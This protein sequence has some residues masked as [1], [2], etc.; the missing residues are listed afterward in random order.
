MFLGESCSRPLVKIEWAATVLNQLLENASILRAC[1]LNA[2]IN[3]DD[4]D[5]LIN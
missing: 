2:N 1:H 3:P 5:K 4:N